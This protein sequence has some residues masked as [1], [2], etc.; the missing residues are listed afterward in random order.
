MSL[1]LIAEPPGIAPMRL[2]LRQEQS[3]RVGSSPWVEFCVPDVELPDEAFTLRYAVAVEVVASEGCALLGRKGQRFERLCLELGDEAG[4]RFDVGQTRFRLHWVVPPRGDQRGWRSEIEQAQSDLAAESLL[5]QRRQQWKRTL[6]RL[7]I[8][9]VCSAMLPEAETEVELIAKLQSRGVLDEARL[10]TLY[11]LPVVAGVRRVLAVWPGWKESY[12]E[13]SHAIEA[14]LEEPGEESR[15]TCARWGMDD[16]LTGPLKYVSQAIGFSGGS[17]APEG[18]P[19]VPPPLELPAICLRV[20]M[21]LIAVAT[22]EL[23]LDA[24]LSETLA[25][26]SLKVVEDDSALTPSRD[27]GGEEP[28]GNAGKEMADATSCTID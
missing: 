10:L 14:W 28:D 20:A 18:Q 9:D 8:C 17:L 7:K 24:W 12:P 25:N 23:D 1:A 15:A 3:A 16:R 11:W 5:Q 13:A 4:V 26:H 22:A 2:L 27:L 19:V 6:E 21:Q